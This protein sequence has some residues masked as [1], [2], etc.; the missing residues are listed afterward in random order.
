M[1]KEIKAKEGSKMRF[2]PSCGARVD[3][4]ANFCMECGWPL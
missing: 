4:N 3:E 1:R 2:C